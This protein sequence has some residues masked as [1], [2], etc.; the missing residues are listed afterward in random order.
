MIVYDDNIKILLFQGYPKFTLGSCWEH[1]EV[2]LGSCW[3]QCEVI[4]GSCWDHRWVILRSCRYHF[5]IILASWKKTEVFEKNV[6]KYVPILVFNITALQHSSLRDF[7]G[8]TRRIPSRR[9]ESGVGVP[10]SK[11]TKNRRR[12]LRS[13]GPKTTLRLELEAPTLCTVYGNHVI[14]YDDHI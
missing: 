1:S 6:S 10:E 4:L 14:M 13:T 2:I 12:K 5:G 11:E 8:A 3:Y 7:L 9:D